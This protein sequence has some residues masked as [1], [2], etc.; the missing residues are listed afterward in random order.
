M[1]RFPPEFAAAP[2]DVL[3]TCAKPVADARAPQCGRL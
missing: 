2:G 3:I 1:H